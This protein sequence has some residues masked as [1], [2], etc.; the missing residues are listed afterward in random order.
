MS[1]AKTLV[2]FALAGALVGAIGASVVVPPVLSWYNATGA[3]APGKSVET[4]CNVPEL[5]RYATR[6]LLLGQMIGA[7]VGAAG[8]VALGVLYT[9]RRS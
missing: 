2:T 6:R 4:L 9:R 7:G 3:I 1:V 5:I 8:A